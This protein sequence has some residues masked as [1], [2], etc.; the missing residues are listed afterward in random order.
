MID[1]NNYKLTPGNKGKNCICNGKHYDNDG[2]LITI[3]CDEC[4]YLM[5]CIEEINDCYSCMV[6]SCPNKKEM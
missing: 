1:K 5:C 4:D 6:A 3:C 2:K